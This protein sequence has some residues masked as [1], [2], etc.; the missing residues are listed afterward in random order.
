MS[1][2][3]WP[4]VALDVAGFHYLRSVGLVTLKDAYIGAVAQRAIEILRSELRRRPKR[5]KA[6]AV[7]K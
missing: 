6:A 2:G 5:S 7:R 4:L 1:A 3:M